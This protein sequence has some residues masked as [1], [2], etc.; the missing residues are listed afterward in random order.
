[1]RKTAK[2]LLMVALVLSSFVVA[3]AS[4]S[5]AECEGGM[6]S[7]SCSDDGGDDDDGSGGCS[8]CV[9]RAFDGFSGQL[10]D[11]SALRAIPV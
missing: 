5:A 11:F 10:T 1:M 6:I 8:T 4:V 3:T 7:P 2:V 9:T